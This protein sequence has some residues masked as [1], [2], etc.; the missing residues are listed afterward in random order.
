MTD[1]ERI[2]VLESGGLRKE[3]LLEEKGDARI[4]LTS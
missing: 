1:S 3:E 2:A 4:L